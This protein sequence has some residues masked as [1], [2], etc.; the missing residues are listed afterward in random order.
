MMKYC[1]L[2]PQYQLRGWIG[3][4]YALVHDGDVTRLTRDEFNA[5]AFCD[6][7]TDTGKIHIKEIQ[8]VAA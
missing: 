6:G 8:P 5:L 4:P 3:M 2:S 1:S 7:K